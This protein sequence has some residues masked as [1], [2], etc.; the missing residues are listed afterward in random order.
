MVWH[1]ED[2]VYKTIPVSNDKFLTET[3][4]FASCKEMEGWES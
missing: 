2:S 3:R 1:Y 4:K